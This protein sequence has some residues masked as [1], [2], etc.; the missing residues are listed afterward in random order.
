MPHTLFFYPQQQIS[1]PSLPCQHTV[2]AD[3]ALIQ[4]H[5]HQCGSSRHKDTA[6]SGPVLRLKIY[7]A[8]FGIT[9]PNTVEWTQQWEHRMI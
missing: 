6:I 4:Q 9:V 3:A 7:T 2:E 5:Y 8:A 1:A